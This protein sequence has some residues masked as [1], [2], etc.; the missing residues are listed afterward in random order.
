MEFHPFHVAIEGPST[1]KL[2]IKRIGMQEQ[3]RAIDL[4]FGSSTG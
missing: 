3:A 2:E 4:A 1:A